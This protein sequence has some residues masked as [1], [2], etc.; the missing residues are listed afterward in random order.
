[1][2]ARTFAQYPIKGIL[3]HWRLITLDDLSNCSTVGSREIKNF[4]N[5][6]RTA[7]A[8]DCFAH[9]VVWRDGIVA[10]IVS[11]NTRTFGELSPSTIIAAYRNAVAGGDVYRDAGDVAN[12]S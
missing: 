11:S 4:A 10:C 8:H 9:L 1:M 2:T 7:T 3:E 12:V 5:A 6:I